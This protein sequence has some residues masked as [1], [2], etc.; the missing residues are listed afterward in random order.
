MSFL[1]PLAGLLALAA[2]PVVVLLYFLR[3]KRIP[4]TVPSTLLWRRSFHDLRANA[5][6]QRLR[7][8]LLL[9]LQLAVLGLVALAL[10]RPLVH[11]LTLAGRNVV[12]CLDVS[13]SMGTREAAG[14]RL[15]RAKAE[16]ESVLAGLGRGDEAMLVTFA[17]SADVVVSFAGTA[18]RI[19][20][21][22]ARV[23]VRE[24]GTDAREALLIGVHALRGRDNPEVIVVSDGA[25]GALPELPKGADVPIRLVVVGEAK[26]NVGLTA[27][28]VRAPIEAGEGPQVFARVQAFGVAADA[29]VECLLGG[30]LVA[31][32]RV[33]ADVD[34]EGAAVFTLP[35]EASG[36][37]EVRLTAGDALA[38]DDVVRTVIAP[39][40][41]LRVGL[42]TIEHYFLEKL[43]P[44]LQRVD[45]V[46][47]SPDA[48]RER[49]AAAALDA[50][51]RAPDV[52][53]LDRDAATLRADL[54]PG[55]YLMLGRTGLPDVVDEGEIP[56]PTILD[57]SRTH[58]VTRFLTFAHVNI[59]SARRWRLPEDAAVLLE[60][61]EGPLIVT[62][63]RGGVRAV[64]VAFD[65]MDSDWWSRL[66]FRLSVASAS[67]GLAGAPGA[68]RGPHQA[69]GE[70]LP[71]DPVVGAA[72]LVVEDP[73]GVRHPI[74][75]TERGAP[76]FRETHRVGLYRVV[77]GERAPREVA[78]NL[79]DPAE[80]RIAPVERLDLPGASAV[81]V[82]R[83][84][85]TARRELWRYAVLLAFLLLLIEWYVYN[86]R[87]L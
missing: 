75:L 78:A 81:T 32:K 84:V 56:M 47:V 60:A 86:R 61:E 10:A 8:N 79:A 40:R 5:P 16:V 70:P 63:A 71:L 59:A 3:L 44:A 74:A 21:E 27:I 83:S 28:E 42:V 48:F 25:L 49:G 14:T 29:D 36:P 20:D 19:R 55:G 80:S 23:T 45:A 17:E 30:T 9:F 58:P 6:F 31:A 33:H 37:C 69:P 39:P 76:A 24:T 11:A 43:L 57:W 53:L 85:S 46:K 41:R 4:R 15:D 62:L 67:D 51:G 7:K 26:D 54:P 34:G 2:V 66:S 12:V 22:L 77:E 64:C 68:A 38:A 13:A 52:W 72:Q 1:A 50:E 73:A 35:P 82:S 18:S 87:A 65:P